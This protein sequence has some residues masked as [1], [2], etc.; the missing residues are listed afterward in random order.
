MFSIMKSG[1]NFTGCLFIDKI[2]K[3]KIKNRSFNNTL[4]Y[5]SFVKPSTSKRVA[6]QVVKTLRLEH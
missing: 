5:A 4:I 3:T 6:M 2:L 1:D